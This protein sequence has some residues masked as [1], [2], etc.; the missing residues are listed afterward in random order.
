M[1]G[2]DHVPWVKDLAT[3]QQLAASKNQLILLHFS[4]H[5]CPPCRQLERKVFSKRTFGHAIG[6]LFV[7]VNVNVSLQPELKQQF[8]IT[9]WPTDVVVTPDGQEVHRMTSMQDMNEYLITLRQVVWRH[10]TTAPGAM[11][12][13]HPLQTSA[14]ATNTAPSFYGTT[15]NT[16][17][18]ATQGSPVPP[19]ASGPSTVQ[20]MAASG[21]TTVQNIY[22]GQ[23]SPVNPGPA[24][25]PAVASDS[26]YATPP[27]IVSPNAAPAVAPPQT[28]PAATTPPASLVNA[29]TNLYPPQANSVYA[30]PAN[31]VASPAASP[32]AATPPPTSVVPATTPAPGSANSTV[33]PATNGAALANSGSAHQ[34]QQASAQMPS[35]Q[36]LMGLEGYC[37]V[38][39]I[40]NEKWEAGDAKWGARHRGRVYLFQTAAAQQR[41][42][43]EPD[44]YSPVLSGFDPMVYLD[45]GQLVEGHRAHGLRFQQSVVLFSSEE[46]LTR[47]TQDPQGYLSRL[48][49]STATAP[50]Q[51][52]TR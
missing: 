45:S 23:Q 13:S 1:D 35:V 47:F 22:V 46:S 8:N 2:A 24:T 42:L 49:Q 27:Q 4:A 17:A 50:G 51:T 3:A 25:P 9:A 20:N 30:T 32:Q 41:F 36:P 31:H 21:P 19:A 14:T 43:A 12:A 40:E 39:L 26:F 37:P 29:Q 33:Q 52:L 48:S 28:A 5:D 7:P 11:V 15:P 44:R 6:E 38:T 16:T 18:V 34:A 10:K